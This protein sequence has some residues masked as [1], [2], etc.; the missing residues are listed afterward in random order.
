VSSSI[1]E[2]KDAENETQ[3]YDIYQ[4]TKNYILYITDVERWKLKVITVASVVKNGTKHK[5]F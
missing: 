5:T 2:T 4:M 3:R 1:N